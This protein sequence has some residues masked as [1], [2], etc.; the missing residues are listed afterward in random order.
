MRDYLKQSLQEFRNQGYALLASDLA[1]KPL[2]TVSGK[3]W[4]LLL[5]NEASG[6]D[7]E[8]LEESDLRMK[9]PGKGDMES[10]N[11]AVALGIFLHHLA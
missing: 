6:I 10:L 4:I 5:G 1:G 11:V 2:H 9:I 8:L 7:S 3:K